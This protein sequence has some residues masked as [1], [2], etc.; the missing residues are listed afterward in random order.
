MYVPS[1]TRFRLI[2]RHTMLGSSCKDGAS[3]RGIDLQKLTTCRKRTDHGVLLLKE[4]REPQP[5]LLPMP[6]ICIG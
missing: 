6:L 5:N 4:A 2:E 3:L 1:S